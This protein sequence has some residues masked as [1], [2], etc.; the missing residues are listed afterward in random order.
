MEVV[1]GKKGS[2]EQLP[3]LP[4]PMA[5]SRSTAGVQVNPEC[6]STPGCPC[7]EVLP[8]PYL[9]GDGVLPM[10]RIS[11]RLQHRNAHFSDGGFFWLLTPW[12]YVMDLVDVGADCILTDVDDGSEGECCSWWHKSH[13]GRAA[14]VLCAAFVQSPG[15]SWLSLQHAY[16]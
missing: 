7:M 14:A 6:E 11:C 13:P 12:R 15:G 1:A 9:L 5:L 4:E 3:A 2:W 16:Q 8:P 10:L